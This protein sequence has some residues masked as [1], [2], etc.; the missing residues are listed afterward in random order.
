MDK[1]KAHIESNK[2]GWFSV[3]REE[4]IPFGI[5]GEGK[6]VSEAKED[7]MNVY[8]AMR[9]AHKERTGEEINLSFEFTLDASA[10]LQQYKNIISLAGL[11]KLTGIHKGQL[12]QYVCG[13]R[14]P[15]PKTQEKIKQAILSFADELSHAFA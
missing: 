2:Q 3:Y 7:F 6:T 12:S 5:L 10:F 11:S 9:M 14:N 8:G 4:D 13:T 1:I 15:T